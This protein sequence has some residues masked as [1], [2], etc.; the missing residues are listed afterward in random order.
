M[1]YQVPDTITDSVY[2]HL[3]Q[4]I[5]DGK[6]KQSERM[7]EREIAQSF[8]VSITPVREAFKILSGEG[9][10]KITPRKEVIVADVTLRDIDELFQVI[11]VLDV[12]AIMKSFDK[13]S[14]DDID[15]VAEMTARLGRYVKTHK[16]SAYV[17]QNLL[18]HEEFWKITG[19]DILY[20]SLM[21]LA[22]KSIF[23]SNRFFSLIDNPS[24]L[25]KSLKDHLDI[26]EVLK[27]RDRARLQSIL[28]AHWG[29]EI[30]DVASDLES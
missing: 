18:I 2:L 27:S 7:R 14:S 12:Y 15:I 19:N 9:Y 24:F 25:K 17:K 8:N 11:G 5:I 3:K 1:G 21:N 22:E 6:F 30:L 28:T 23:F 10:L 16:I 20:Q 4:D 29:S 13:I 26:I